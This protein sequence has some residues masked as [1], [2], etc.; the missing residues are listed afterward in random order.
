VIGLLLTGPHHLLKV[1]AA[2]LIIVLA[3]ST[4]GR[5]ALGGYTG[6]TLGATEQLAECAVLLVLAASA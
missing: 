6:D 2:T 4:L 5:R 3:M 1:A